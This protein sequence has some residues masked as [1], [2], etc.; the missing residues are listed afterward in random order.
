MHHATPANSPADTAYP[1]FTTID[2]F[3][4]RGIEIVPNPVTMT[5][6]NWKFFPAAPLEKSRAGR[7]DLGIAYDVPLDH[8]ENIEGR[9]I[10]ALRRRH[11]QRV[12]DK[13][14]TSRGWKIK[15]WD[16]GSIVI[17]GVELINVKGSVR[18][19]ED[20]GKSRLVAYKLYFESA[21]EALDIVDLVGFGRMK[22]S[23]TTAYCIEMPRGIRDNTEEWFEFLSPKRTRNNTSVG[24]KLVRI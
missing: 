23:Q 7:Y 2:T 1:T 4:P 13:L 5:T 16:D 9:R 14:T 11:I 12:L 22:A 15:E 24:Q 10:A 19:D 8:M 6:L 18:R 3:L 21:T 17:R 20:T